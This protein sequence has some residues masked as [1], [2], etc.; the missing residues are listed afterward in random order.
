M[1]SNFSGIFVNIIII[2]IL[3]ITLVL[4][5]KFFE[6]NE[7]EHLF[8]STYSIE[9]KKLSTKKSNTV[10]STHEIHQINSAKYK[11]FS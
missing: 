7:I 5:T 10:F 8:L 11:T 1:T 6:L 4:S 2:Q 9:H 3:K